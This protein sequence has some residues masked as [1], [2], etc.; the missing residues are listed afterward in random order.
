M[1]WTIEKSECHVQ[2]LPKSTSLDVL[3][4]LTSL[5]AASA[6]TSLQARTTLCWTE[7][8]LWMA[9]REHA[10]LLSVHRHRLAPRDG[11]RTERAPHALPLLDARCIDHLL[12]RS[13]P[14]AQFPR[15]RSVAAAGF[16]TLGHCPE[17]MLRAAGLRR[18]RRHPGPANAIQPCTFFASQKSSGAT[19][20][21]RMFPLSTRYKVTSIREYRRPSSVGSSRNAKVSSAS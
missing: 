12:T 6:F 18:R 1:P 21:V 5:P 14:G 19:S 20:A 10:G 16:A 4:I 9:A 2:L 3:L 17:E 11:E 15:Q 8:A 13:L 7:R